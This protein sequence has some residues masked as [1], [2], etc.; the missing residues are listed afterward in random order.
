MDNKDPILAGLARIEA[1]QDKILER[2]DELDAEIRE[3]RQDC[4]R[5]AAIAGGLSGGMVAAGIEF[6]RIKFGG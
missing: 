1:K 3:I 6:I 5:S 4:R 2:Q